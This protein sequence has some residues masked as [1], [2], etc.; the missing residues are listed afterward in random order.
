MALELLAGPTR[1]RLAALV[2]RLRPLL[3]GVRWVRPEGLHLTL[4]FLGGRRPSALALVGAAASA[5]AAR[6]CP[7]ADVRLAGSSACFPSAAA[8]GCCGW[9]SSCPLPMLALQEACE[10]GRLHGR[11]RAGGPA[12]RART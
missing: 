8:R 6:A 10:R 3:P 1:D 5:P 9:G 2:E 11:I 12:V 7:P 4:R